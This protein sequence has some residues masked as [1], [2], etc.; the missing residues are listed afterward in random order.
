MGGLNHLLADSGAGVS[1]ARELR[2]RRCSFTGALTRLLQRNRTTR[3][4]VQMHRKRFIM[5]EWLMDDGG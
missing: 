1:D 4:Y 2:L 3:M 5:R